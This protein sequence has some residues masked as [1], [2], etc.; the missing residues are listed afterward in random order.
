MVER[1]LAELEKHG[2]VDVQVDAGELTLLLP[3]GQVMLWWTC[4]VVDGVQRYR[5][6]QEHCWCPT[7]GILRGKLGGAS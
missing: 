1:T 5:L 3:D 7:S 4:G 2:L 6:R